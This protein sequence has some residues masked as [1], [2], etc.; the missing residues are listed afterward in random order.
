MTTVPLTVHIMT[1]AMTP[2]D[3][4][5]NYI[6]SSARIWREWGVRVEIFADYVAPVY[7]G[8]VKPTILYPATGDAL[9]WYH[10]SIY[11]DNIE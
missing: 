3:A 8:L 10:Y 11:A 2:G 9:L 7:G 4:I 6:L 5:G 1:A